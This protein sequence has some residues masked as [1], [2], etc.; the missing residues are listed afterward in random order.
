MRNKNYLIIFIILIGGLIG[1][2]IWQG[3]KNNQASPALIAFARCL[4]EKEAIVYG[5]D[6]C[7]WCQK[8]KADFKSAWQFIKYVNCVNDPQTCTSLNIESTPTW[9]FQGGKRL[10][11]YQQ[12]DSL[13]EA[14]G[15]PITETK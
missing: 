6:S 8:Q 9:I 1:F 11:G 4:T 14:S 3:N 13:S 7:E 12:L 15:C 10:V 2:L 5:T